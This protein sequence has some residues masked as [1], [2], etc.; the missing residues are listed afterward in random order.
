MS[1][2]T[3]LDEKNVRRMVSKVRKK[4]KYLWTAIAIVPATLVVV[5]SV[6]DGIIECRGIGSIFTVVR[7]VGRVLAAMNLP[8]VVTIHVNHLGCRCFRIVWA[9][10]RTG[11][12][13][14]AC[15]A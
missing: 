3:R 1:A 15:T 6:A 9:L 8:R 12:A 11:S 10:H 2:A 5:L 7:G 14:F 13:I 4:R